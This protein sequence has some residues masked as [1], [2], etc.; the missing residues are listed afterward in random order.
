MPAGNCM[1]KAGEG[2]GAGRG[3]GGEDSVSSAHTGP[4]G[5]ESGF[6]QSVVGIIAGFQQW[7]HMILPSLWLLHGR[8]TGAEQYLAAEIGYSHCT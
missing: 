7:R 5:K 2:V 6:I 1:A 4:S 8:K 3:L